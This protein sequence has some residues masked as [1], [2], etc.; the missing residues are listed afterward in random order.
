MEGCSRGR[1]GAAEDTV[2]GVKTAIVRNFDSRLHNIMEE[3]GLGPLFDMKLWC[4]LMLV[5]RSRILF[6]FWKRVG[7]V[8]VGDDRRNDLYGARDAG[9]FAWLCGDDVKSFEQVRKRLET[10]TLYGS[11]PGF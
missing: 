5:R 7:V 3:L 6:W 8:H 1:S 10:G 2:K 4:R 9:C 11:L